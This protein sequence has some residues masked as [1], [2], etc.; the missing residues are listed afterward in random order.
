MG[1]RLYT[2]VLWSGGAVGGKGAWMVDV[3]F[4]KSFLGDVFPRIGSPMQAWRPN[5]GDLPL[6]K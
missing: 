4:A 1:G 6:W 3:Y 5:E 2:C